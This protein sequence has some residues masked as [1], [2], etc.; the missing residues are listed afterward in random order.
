MTGI[1]SGQILTYLE[2]LG[3]CIAAVVKGLPLSSSFYIPSNVLKLAK[4]LED[5]R[6]EYQTLAAQFHSVEAWCLLPCFKSRLREYFNLE[7]SMQDYLVYT[8]S[9]LQKN[10][11]ES[12]VELLKKTVKFGWPDTL[13]CLW[14]F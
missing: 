12:A 14:C 4:H 2:N 6:L 7:R 10:D 8:R 5:D 1:L 13:R 11:V 3:A 9:L